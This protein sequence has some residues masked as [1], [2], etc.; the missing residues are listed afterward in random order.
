MID[1]KHKGLKILNTCCTWTAYMTVTRRKGEKIISYRNHSV[2]MIK[3]KS[4]SQRSIPLPV[5]REDLILGHSMEKSLAG[6]RQHC[7]KQHWNI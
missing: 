7:P 6:Y 1:V 2:Y 3:K 4:V 5:A